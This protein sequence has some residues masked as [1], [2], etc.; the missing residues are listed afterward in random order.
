MEIPEDS[1][2]FHW[3]DCPCLAPLGRNFVSRARWF[4]QR[5]RR[6]EFQ[7]EVMRGT[8][9]TA[10]VLSLEGGLLDLV[11]TVHQERIAAQK[12]DVQ[13]PPVMEEIQPS[14]IRNE[15]RRRD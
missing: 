12:V 10:V 8:I 1:L 15:S 7:R 6:F 14:F 5:S 13:M 9:D 2:R 3:S 4:F 11:R